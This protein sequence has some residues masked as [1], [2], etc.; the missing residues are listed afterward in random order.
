MLDYWRSPRSNSFFQSYSGLK[1]LLLFYNI[2]LNTPP[3]TK[4][5]YH[6]HTHYPYQADKLKWDTKA[7][8][9]TVG[10]SHH[11]EI[12]EQ[13]ASPG[14]PLIPAQWY[15]GV[16]Q[17]TSTALQV[18]LLYTMYTV[19]YILYTMHTIHYTLYNIQCTPYT[20]FNIFNLE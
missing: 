11:R 1:K 19:H 7:I 12:L 18:C 3:L 8:V 14:H 5:N 10:V 13:I 6:H 16:S 15:N 9:M 20:F 17:E 4:K 2:L